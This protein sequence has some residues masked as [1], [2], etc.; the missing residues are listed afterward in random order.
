M[1]LAYDSLVERRKRLPGGP[2]PRGPGRYYLTLPWIP[3]FA[4]PHVFANPDILGVLDRAFAQ[5]YRMVQSAVD[6]PVLGSGYQ[7]AHRDHRP[8]FREDFETP[9][10]A[11]AVNF[12]LCD[13]S[14][15]NGPLEMARGTHRMSKARAAEALASGETRMEP[16]PCCPRRTWSIGNRS[17]GP[18]SIPNSGP[19]SGNRSGLPKSRGR[20]VGSSS[21]TPSEKGIKG[22][23]SGSPPPQGRKG[24]I[25]IR[26]RP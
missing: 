21:T 3:P 11:L 9:L 26:A 19:L 16:S 8:L 25:T 2:A 6:T 1:G 12:P 24:P 20:R 7:A 18:W 17:A 10:F 5:E 14:E 15:E 22:L 4:D 13:V 23:N